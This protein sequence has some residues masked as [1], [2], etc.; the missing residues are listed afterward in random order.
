MPPRQNEER[1][2]DQRREI[3]GVEM[4]HILYHRGDALKARRSEVVREDEDILAVIQLINDL[5]EILSRRIHRLSAGYDDIGTQIIE[6]L[7]DALTGSDS[8]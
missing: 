7:C 1:E 8:D 3:A 4:E 2:I 5:G 6:E